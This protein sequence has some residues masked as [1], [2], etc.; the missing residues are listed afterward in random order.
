MALIVDDGTGLSNSNSYADVATASTYI[1]QFYFST[2]ANSSTWA[3]ASTADQEVALMRATRDIDA[4]FGQSYLSAPLS[5]TQA[6]LFPRS[7]FYQYNKQPYSVPSFDGMW[8][9]S[10]DVDKLITG[11]PVGLTN[12]TI[13]MALILLNGFDATGP[14]DRSGAIKLDKSQIGTIRTEQEYFYPT[15]STASA[16]RK[17]SSLLQPYLSISPFGANVALKRG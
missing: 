2:D 12:A 17:V 8:Y 15:S 6:L 16:L 1:A 3:D 7:P 11:I 4:I 13:E 14:A 10:P 5:N 9:V